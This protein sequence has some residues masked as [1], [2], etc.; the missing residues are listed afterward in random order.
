[1][2]DVKQIALPP[3]ART[4][5]VDLNGDPAAT[6]ENP[7]RPTTLQ[8]ALATA[9]FADAIVLGNGVYTT[10]APIVIPVSNLTIT[11]W[12]GTQTSNNTEIDDQ[13]VIPAGITRLRLSCIRLDGG[14]LDQGS[15]GRHYFSF[16]NVNGSSIQ[17]IN[18]RRWFDLENCE[19]PSAPVSI[20]GVGSFAPEFGARGSLGTLSTVTC[21]ATGGVNV[22][23][24][25]LRRSGRVTLSNGAR[26]FVQNA[27]SIVDNTQAV[28]ADAST[29]VELRDSNL[30]NALGAPTA[31]ALSG[32]YQLTGTVFDR[33]TSTLG[34]DVANVAAFSALRVETVPANPTAAE[35]FAVG[36][37]GRLE[38]R[39]VASLALAQ[40]GP[41][42]AQTTTTDGDLASPTA[43]TLQPLGAVQVAINGESVPPS[44]GVTTGA[45]FFSGDGGSTARAQGAIVPGDLLYWNGSVAGYELAPTDDV[46]LLG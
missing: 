8:N 29:Y 25:D 42:A 38:R 15:E 5:F 1:M 36:A 40:Q 24:S 3:Y 44:Y 46:V 35:L 41:F 4:L 6:G 33:A 11:S 39:P 12:D 30:L 37:Q 26:A 18:P 17:R 34:T 27:K 23:L 28:V 13:I 7:A 19:C 43:V 2:I 16:V 9:A 45:C 20:T 21:S 14:V 31:V 32:T 10:G 22:F